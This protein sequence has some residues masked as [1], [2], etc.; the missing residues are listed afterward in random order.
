M[1]TNIA[2]RDLVAGDFVVTAPG[3]ADPTG[4]VTLVVV[5]WGQA[6]VWLDTYPNGLAHERRTADLILNHGDPVTITRQGGTN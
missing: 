2:A 3:Y 1:S 6:T 5:E 4:Q